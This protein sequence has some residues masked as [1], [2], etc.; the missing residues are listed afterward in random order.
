MQKF[1]DRIKYFNVSSFLKRYEHMCVRF[2]N[3][4][5][6]GDDSVRTVENIH[7]LYFRMN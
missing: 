7:L 3:Q 5:R 1:T 2:S 6:D 4:G